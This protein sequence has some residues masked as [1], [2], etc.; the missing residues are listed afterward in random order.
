MVRLGDT[1][2]LGAILSAVVGVL[3]VLFLATGVYYLRLTAGASPDAGGVA[4]PLSL[5]GLLAA[6][7]GVAGL[8]VSLPALGLCWYRLRTSE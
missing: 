5:I 2:R 6:V 7:L 4:A 3:S 1:Y 8:L